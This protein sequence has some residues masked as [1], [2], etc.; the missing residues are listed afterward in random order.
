MFSLCQTDRSETN[1]NTQ[2]KWTVSDQIKPGQPRRMALSIRDSFFEFPTKVKRNEEGNELVCQ[3]VKENLGPNGWTGQ[4]GLHPEVV[5]NILVGRNRN[6]PFHF[7]DL[8]PK[9]PE[10]LHIKRKA[11][12]TTSTMVCIEGILNYFSSVAYKAV[13]VT[14]LPHIIWFYIPFLFNV[15]YITDCTS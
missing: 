2:E 1:R 5:P 15:S 14:V 3:I 12:L 8:Q 10:S 13:T 4:S 11:P 7:C 9:F 6:G